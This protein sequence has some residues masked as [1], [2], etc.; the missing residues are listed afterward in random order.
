MHDIYDVPRVSTCL[1]ILTSWL[2]TGCSLLFGDNLSLV[3]R[4][5][6]H[7]YVPSK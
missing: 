7:M 2:S 6:I 5:V 4:E 3:N 1:S